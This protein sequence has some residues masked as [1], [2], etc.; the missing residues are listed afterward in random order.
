M[1]SN[2]FNFFP[3]VLFSN[4]YALV[5]IGVYLIDY[6]V[7]R[8]MTQ[9]EKNSPAEMKDRFSFLVIQGAGIIGIVLAVLCR[10][11]KILVTS[12][13]VQWLGL[14]LAVLGLVFREWAV[15]ILGRNFSRVVVI[16]SDQKLVTSGP[17][18]WI[19]HP[20]YTGMVIIYLGLSLGLGS[21][22]GVLITIV[23]ILASTLYRINVEE[24]VLLDAWGDE[25][26][27]YMKKTW[28]LFPGC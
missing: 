14:I 17:Y 5:L 7:V 16:K 21:W 18:R 23:L 13:F 1:F 8:R 10:Y 25:Y 2:P 24:R 22:V 4:L 12:E 3:S 28:K 6:L 9:N 26:R 19:R 11:F 20:A 15:I 27:V